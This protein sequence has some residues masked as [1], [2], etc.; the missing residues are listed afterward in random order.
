MCQQI[1]KGQNLFVHCLDLITFK[2]LK[3][4][5]PGGPSFHNFAANY[6]KTIFRK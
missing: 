2:K 6:S 4:L 3:N 5:L 1:R